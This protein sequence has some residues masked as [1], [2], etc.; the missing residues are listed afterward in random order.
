MSNRINPLGKAM[1]GERICQEF[2]ACE[3][4][5]KSP[6]TAPTSSGPFPRWG[7]EGHARAILCRDRKQ[8]EEDERS[9]VLKGLLDNITGRRVAP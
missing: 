1:E 7:A 3:E 6:P 5:D 4:A 9:G 2:C 8:T